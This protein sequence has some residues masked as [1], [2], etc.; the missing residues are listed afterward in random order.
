MRKFQ[1]L[2]LLCPVMITSCDLQPI[3]GKLSSPVSENYP[4][5]G[6]G[7]VSA[8]IAW[9]SFFTD[10]RLKKLVGTALERNR[11]LKVAALNVEQARAQYGISRSQLFPTVNLGGTAS[12]SRTPE[13]I[14][15]TGASYETRNYSVTVGSASYELDLFGRVRS[16][17]Q[18]ALQSYFATDAAR[19]SV[20]I[21]LVSE[22]ASQYF[23]ERALLEQIK[24]SEQTL[25]NASETY[26]LT[27]KRLSAGQISELDLASV[28]VQVQTAKANLINYRQQL[29]Q[30]ENALAFLLGGAVPSG[31]PEG[32]TLEE[33]IVADVR[34]GVSSDLLRRRP[35][36]REAEHTLR[37]ANANIGAARAAF[38]PRITLTGSAG[39][40][41]K[42]LSDL[43]EPGT[44]TW[45]FAPQI[46]VPIFTGGSNKAN[47]DAANIRKQI[48]IVNY[49]KAIQTG[50][51]E[52]ADGLAARS[53]LNERI[54][55]YEA[56]VSAQ[57]KRY[58]L[59]ERR[60]KEGL[61]SYFQVLS[62]QQDL[63]NASQSLI[64]LRLS[65]VVN[66][67]TLYKALG[68]GW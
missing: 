61:D 9:Q 38:F 11:D 41:T 63:Y 14:S 45:S 51:R 10:A 43:F 53:G 36:I 6:G 56:L 23:T 44:G 40:T 17:N 21:S 2:A 20:Q 52:V 27:Q 50:F 24:L 28:D 60:Y 59:S 1:Y 13:S 8:D 5:N 26:S 37:S 46:S 16:L 55:A 35:D 42:S 30:T 66:S 31:L 49:E 18:A 4:G 12:Q 62:A 47:L 22:V 54:S 68:G 48:E 34:S 25:S 7:E 29:A 3:L 32:K 58:D 19:L 64:Q 67:C 15:A 33:G 57:Q 65:R 39:T